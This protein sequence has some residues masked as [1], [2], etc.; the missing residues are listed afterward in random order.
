M[1][2]PIIEESQE[3]REER[4]HRFAHEVRNEMEKVLKKRLL[5]GMKKGF[6]LVA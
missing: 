3:E 2:G 6:P 1:S 5:M 4:H